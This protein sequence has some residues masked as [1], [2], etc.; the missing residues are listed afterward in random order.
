MVNL[1]YIAEDEPFLFG[2]PFV[3]G[4]EDNWNAPITPVF[5]AFCGMLAVIQKS[6][7]PEMVLK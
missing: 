6:T 1:Y 2:M 7:Q 5:I 3:S 4:C